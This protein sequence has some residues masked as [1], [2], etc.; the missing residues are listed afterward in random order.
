M[1][2]LSNAFLAETLYL[3][4]WTILCLYLC[5]HCTDSTIDFRVTP[6]SVKPQ[7]TGDLTFL[8]R[9]NDTLSTSTSG[10]LVGRDLS[11]TSDLSVT[12]DPSDLDDAPDLT[13]STATGIV[14]IVS[15]IISDSM[16]DVIATVSAY[17]PASLLSQRY[18]DVTVT[19]ELTAVKGVKG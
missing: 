4:K 12:S 1:I 5:F 7:L 8:C 3:S 6:T 15:I 19:G 13:T 10:S 2:K 17:Q 16:H 14:S 18:T 9:L 11:L